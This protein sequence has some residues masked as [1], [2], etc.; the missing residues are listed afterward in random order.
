MK[1]TIGLDKS[2][3]ELL[4]QK[5]NLLLANYQMFYINARGFH[6]NIKGEKFFELHAKFEELYTDAVL[7]IDAI[8]ERVL[9]L[10]HTPMHTYE[11]YLAQSTIKP[12]KEVSDGR[13]CVEH[14]V[15]GFQTLLEI[16]REILDLSDETGDEGTNAQM[17][18]YITE[19]EKTVW[20]YNAFLS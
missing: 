1:N 9:T 5:L 8:A 16:E 2:K 15:V 19:Q 13:A 17:S 4:A 7:K 12:A 3:S 6:W 10:G 11:D 20:M 14:I 18:D